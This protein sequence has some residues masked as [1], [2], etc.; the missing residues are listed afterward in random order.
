MSDTAMPI[1]V[2][3]TPTPGEA[4][5]YWLK[6]GFISFGGPAGQIAMMHQEL[7]ERRRWISEHR[8]LHALNYCMLLPGPEA[9]QLAIYIS[10][11]MHGVKGAIMAGVLFFLPAFVLLSVL[12]GIYLSY[13]DV[14]AMQG[15]F[16][17]MKPAVVA[18]VLFAAWRIGSRSIKNGILF[19]I[20]ALAFIG[21]FFFDIDFP[22]IVLAAAI[23]G[24]LGGKLMPAKFK[25]GGGHGA[26]N[27]TYGPA[28][29]DDDTPP[30]AHAKFSSGKLAATTLVFLVIGVASLLVLRGSTDLFKMGEFFIGAAFLTIGGAYAVLPYVYQGAVEHF[31]WL[32]GPQMMDGL[33]LG[34]TTPGP[35]IM[36]VTWVGYMG[37][38]TKSVLGDPITAG[39]AGAAVATFFTFL[40]SFWF[41]IAGG[42]LVEATR[43]ELKFTAPLTAITAAV[44]GVILNLAVFFAWHTFW[45]KGS[46]AMPFGGPFESLQMVIAIAA[47][48][49]LWK[50]KVDIMKMIGA[51][52][53]LGLVLS[54]IR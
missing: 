36:I 15:V 27:A 51:C 17:A 32:T 35:L 38:V 7:V 2:P 40:P 23:L 25:G 29:I 37:G 8:Y 48:I 5:K 12:A 30:P 41:I 4:F 34:E 53:A 1:A 28:I 3:P 24:A 10:W 31:G 54:F 33:A 39:L 20:A 22:W 52:A 18:V 43:G 46:K 45:P 6:L 9:I 49:A 11:L 42:P 47:F 14:P 26:S 21:I 13:G 19:G 16:Y 50:Y 44:V